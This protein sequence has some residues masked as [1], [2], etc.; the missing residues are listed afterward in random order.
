MPTR[1]QATALLEEGRSYEEAARLLG[2][3]AGQVYLIVTG[4]PADGTPPTE[5]EERT[6]RVLP[7]SSQHLVNPVPVNPTRS[8]TT[9]AWVRRRATRDLRDGAGDDA[10][11][12]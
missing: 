8:D 1:A 3:P 9:M 12:A 4:L 11:S 6:R 5:A 10:G 2:I 7:G